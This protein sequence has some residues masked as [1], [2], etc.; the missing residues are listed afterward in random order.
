MKY[1]DPKIYEIKNDDNVFSFD[2]KL[3]VGNKVNKITSSLD[4]YGQVI[5]MYEEGINELCNKMKLINKM[6]CIYLA[7]HICRESGN[8]ICGESDNKNINNTQ[9]MPN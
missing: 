4:R 7:Y 9:D 1:I 5:F 3:A 6:V 2:L 8:K